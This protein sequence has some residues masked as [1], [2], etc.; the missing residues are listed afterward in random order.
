MRR[1]SSGLDPVVTRKSRQSQTA[2]QVRGG[3]VVTTGIRSGG[4][5]HQHNRRV[6]KVRSG[7]KAGGIDPNHNVIARALASVLRQYADP[8]RRAVAK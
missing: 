4:L 3:L 6:L 8:I 7:L 2:R 1:R 5:T